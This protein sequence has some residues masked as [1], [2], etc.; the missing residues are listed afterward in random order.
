MRVCL[1]HTIILQALPTLQNQ[2]LEYL[3][4]LGTR[5]Y[6][7]YGI[8]KVTCANDRDGDDS[9]ATGWTAVGAQGSSLFTRNQ[10]HDTPY[11]HH[12]YPHRPWKRRLGWVA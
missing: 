3:R 8:A 12:R 6:P 7:V 5:T 10:H 9:A 11:R 2:V 1:S 4:K